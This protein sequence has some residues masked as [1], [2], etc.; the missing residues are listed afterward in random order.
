MTSPNRE[1]FSIADL[2]NRQVNVSV[3][4]AVMAA[5]RT[6]SLHIVPNTARWLCLVR[7]QDTSGVLL[8]VQ[9]PTIEQGNHIIFL[10]WSSIL[11]IEPNTQPQP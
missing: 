3:S 8:Q 10:P 4:D 1:S 2:M 7:Q 11:A 6:A 5:L 9:S